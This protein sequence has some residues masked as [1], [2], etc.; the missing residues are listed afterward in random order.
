VPSRPDI[1]SSAA[2]RC[3]LRR[4]LRQPAEGLAGVVLGERLTEYGGGVAPTD[5]NRGPVDDPQLSS[6]TDRTLPAGSVN[7]AMSGPP[8]RNMPFSSM[9]ASMPG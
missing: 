1:G 8:P 2:A 7:H 3:Q 9:S 6:I 4:L 5:R